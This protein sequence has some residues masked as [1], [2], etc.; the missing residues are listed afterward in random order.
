MPTKLF[1]NFLL[2]AAGG[3]AGSMFRYACSL[4]LTPVGT[5]FFWG[6]FVAN[7]AGTLLIGFIAELAAIKAHLSPEIRLLL[8]TGFCGGLTTLSSLVFEANN[9]LRDREF[10]WALAYGLATLLFAFVALWV[11]IL[12]CRLVFIR[13]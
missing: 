1:F 7:I 4:W 12:L 8:M 11:G 10:L 6:T 2:V 3:A 9:L 13:N 5:S